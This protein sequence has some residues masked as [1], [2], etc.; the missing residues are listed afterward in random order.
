MPGAGRCRRRRANPCGGDGGAPPS[1]GTGSASKPSCRPTAPRGLAGGQRRSRVPAAIREGARTPACPLFGDA[2]RAAVLG[3]DPQ[4]PAPPGLPPLPNCPITRAWLGC[5]RE[6]CAPDCSVP[7]CSAP[8]AGCGA[9]SAATSGCA[10]TLLGDGR[11]TPEIAPCGCGIAFF[12]R[13]ALPGGTVPG[14]G[15]RP[16]RRAQAPAA[17]RRIP[18]AFPRNFDGC[19]LTPL[20]DASPPPSC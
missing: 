8:D 6:P 18:R 13:P 9:S 14:A 15:I 11:H 7:W 10:S 2:E 5:P 3:L 12:L 1:N 17:R 20:E 19:V 16:R 4:T